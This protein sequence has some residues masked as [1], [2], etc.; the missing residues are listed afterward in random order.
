[1]SWDD[2][3]PK[4]KPIITVGENLERL[5]VA[6]LDERIQALEAEIVRVQAERRAKKSL[7]SAA[8][9]LFKG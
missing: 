8:E 7:I 5:S 1:M 3:L 6:D 4:P 9:E 2:E